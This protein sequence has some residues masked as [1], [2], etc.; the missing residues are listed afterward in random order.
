VAHVSA[1]VW[2]LAL[3][4]YDSVSSPA[5]VE[6]RQG[7]R[8]SCW[9]RYGPGMPSL[10][11]AAPLPA[12][13]LL[14]GPP[15]T[16]RV[17]GVH[18]SCLYVVTDPPE[19]RLVAVETADAL[20]LPCALRL[21]LDRGDRPFAGVSSGDRARVGDHRVEL[22]GPTVR[23]VRWWAPPVVRPPSGGEPRWAELAGLL[24]DVRPPARLDDG[25]HDADPLELLGWGSGLTPA[26]DDVLAGWLLAVHHH[27]AARDELLPV[28]AAARHATSALSA[29]LLEEA[30]GGR[31]VPAALAVADA[32][33]G[34]GDL[35]ELGA[36]LDRLLRVGHTSGAALAHGLLR[37]AR[38]VADVSRRPV[39]SRG[40]MS[41]STPRSHQSA[42]QDAEA[43]A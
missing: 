28:V 36:A 11:A 8:L 16:G 13:D 24:R 42:G 34:H 10:P 26:G 35:P 40:G 1:K 33:C 37:G 25:H 14:A 7:C 23:V 20:G 29:A 6:V 19:P 41:L 27:A 43:A 15:R 30:A 18:P 17:V 4:C 38:Q 3:V 12:R 5:L 31:G 39:S 9:T 32:L 2:E 22:G 21:G